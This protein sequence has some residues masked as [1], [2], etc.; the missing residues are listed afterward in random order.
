MRMPASEIQDAAY[1]IQDFIV[2]QG[3]V[4]MVVMG[5]GET[6]VIDFKTDHI[7]EQE[8]ASR[9]DVY[10]RQLDLYQRAVQIILKPTGPVSKWLYFLSLGK[11]MQM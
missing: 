6:Y 5:S 7:Q 4:D 2:V 8:L 9:T 11:G 10:R 1:D 3:I